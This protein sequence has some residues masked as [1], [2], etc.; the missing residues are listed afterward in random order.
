MICENP[1]CRRTTPLLFAKLC[2][3]CHNSRPEKVVKKR[4][5]RPK[6]D[7]VREKQRVVRERKA[8]RLG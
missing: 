2:E 6:P 4:V 5:M 8:R 1:L 7:W 3:G